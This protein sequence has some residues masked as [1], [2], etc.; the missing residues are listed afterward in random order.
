MVQPSGG[1]GGSC[2]G[3]SAL[4]YPRV[5]FCLETFCR[6]FPLYLG[7][8]HYFRPGM[9]GIVIGKNCLHEKI[10][11]INCLPQRCI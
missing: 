2:P 3:G 7:T 11:E 1:G 10:A 6:V 5:E 9:G 4:D 8:D